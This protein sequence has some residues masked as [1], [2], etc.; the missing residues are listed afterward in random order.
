MWPHLYFDQRLC[1]TRTR[2]SNIRRTRRSLIS[3]RRRCGCGGGR[4]PRRRHAAEL[5]A[6]LP[7]EG[8]W[9]HRQFC[10][11]VTTGCCALSST[12]LSG[13]TWAR[14][15]KLCE[16][17]ARIHGL[18]SGKDSALDV[19]TLS[20]KGEQCYPRPR[21]SKIVIRKGA[22]HVNPRAAVVWREC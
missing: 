7:H 19:L 10:W 13:P 6:E 14:R 5:E 15:R 20:H 8:L 9:P 2:L 12:C 22:G 11:R 3:C 16:A 21:A 18:C 17:P 4:R 1:E